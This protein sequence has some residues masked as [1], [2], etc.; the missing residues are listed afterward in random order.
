MRIGALILAAGRASRFGADKRLATLPSGRS[1]LETVLDKFSQ[2]CP[3]VWVVLRPGDEAGEQLARQSGAHVVWC[4]QADLGMGHSLACG[5]MALLAAEPALDGI[6]IGLADMPFVQ[7]DSIHRV[8][9]ALTEHGRAVLPMYRGQG[10]HPR[11]VP[12]ALTG[13][14]CQLQGDQGARHALDWKAALTLD[15][16]DPGVLRDVDRPEDLTP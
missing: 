8:C 12:R 11:G 3:P 1:L 6:V 13:P 2:A 16:D 9:Q 4:A 7:V 5:T 10:G 15:L 14:L